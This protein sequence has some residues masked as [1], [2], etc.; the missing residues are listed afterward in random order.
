MILYHKKD[1]QWM[2]DLFN[3]FNLQI[4]ANKEI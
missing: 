4:F 3:R 2:D 1:A